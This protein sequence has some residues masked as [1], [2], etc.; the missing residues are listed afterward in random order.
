MLKIQNGKLTETEYCIEAEAKNAAIFTTGNGYMGVRGS[1]EEFGSI[2]VQGIYVR[3][4][5]GTIIEIM[6]PFPDNEYMKNFYFN[7][8]KLK[9][10]EKQE[11]VINLSD[12]LLS[13]EGQSSFLGEDAGSGDGRSRAKGRLG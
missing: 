2:R 7:E 6:E 12:C 1:F 10:F 4:Y 13:L 3:G 11:S 8:E 9:D 5:I